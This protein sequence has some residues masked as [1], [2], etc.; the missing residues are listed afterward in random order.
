METD[1]ITHIMYVHYEW[2]TCV[3]SS[4]KGKIFVSLK[5]LVTRERLFALVATAGF[6]Q[7]PVSQQQILHPLIAISLLLSSELVIDH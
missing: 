2:Q 6:V 4:D 3:A 7:V 5:T 1:D